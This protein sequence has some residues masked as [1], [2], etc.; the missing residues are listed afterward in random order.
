MKTKT[1]LLSFGLAA[2]LSAVSVATVQAREIKVAAGVPPT[3]AAHFGMEA[4]SK[5]LKDRPAVDLDPKI[6]PMSLLNPSQMFAGIRDGVVD[7]GYIVLPLFSSELPESQLVVDLAMLGNNGLAMA[8]AMTEYNFSCDECLAERL[9]NNHVY[10]GSA[11]TGPYWILSTKKIVTLDELK[12][13]KLRFAAAPWSRWAQHMGAVAM[14][15]PG[16][17]IFEAVSQG[18]IDGA[19]VPASELSGLRLGDLVK[20][21]TVGLPGG[22][23]HGLELPNFNRGT[24]RALS[25][26]QRKAVIDAAAIASAATTWRFVKNVTR[27]MK[28]AQAK[29]I[30]IHQPPQDVLARSKAFIEADLAAVAQSAEKNAGI[31]NASQK[32]ARFRQLV[33][34]WEKLTPESA[35]LEP[36]ALAEIY[37]REIFSKIDAKTYGM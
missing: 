37:R 6:F 23:L 31:K 25:E 7:A 19:L 16:Q 36:A 15:I 14:N 30:Q 20:H 24:W 18:T 9:K 34:K 17:D 1:V 5:A 8:G 35:N 4:F 26:P 32:I 11:S 21:I 22:T 29:G 33:D 13:K 12:G 27:N 10:L 2:A 28:D 3:H